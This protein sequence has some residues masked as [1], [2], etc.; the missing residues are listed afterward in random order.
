MS[1]RRQRR[2]ATVWALLVLPALVSLVPL[3]HASPLDP[4]WIAGIY[5]AADFDDAVLAATTLD[6]SV[7]GSPSYVILASDFAAP[8]SPVNRYAPEAFV[9]SIQARAPPR[10]S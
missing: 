7:G 8:Q 9:G 2:S 3:A 1:S 10:T 6:G 5:D 4:S